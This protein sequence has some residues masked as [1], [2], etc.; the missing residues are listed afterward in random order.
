[1]Q[2]RYVGT[3]RSR[4]L[5]LGLAA[6]TALV[7]ACSSSASTTPTSSDASSHGTSTQKTEA[8][9]AQKIVDQ[10]LKPPTT[11]PQTTPLPKA[12]PKGKT[13]VWLQC[14]VPTCKEIGQGI[15]AAAAAV[16]W[17]L[18]TLS[19][20]SGNPSTLIAAMKQALQY[21]PVGVALSGLPQA[22]WS[23]EIPQYAKAHVPI[24]PSY[25]GANPT[26]STVPVDLVGQDFAELNAKLMAN[27]IIADSGA[28][29]HVLNVGIPTFPILAEF[30]QGVQ[31]EVTRGCG[32][33]N[34]TSLSLSLPDV[35][36]GKAVPLIVSALRRT[37]S[38]KYVVIPDAA[39]ITGLP[40]AL[41]AAGLSGIKVLGENADAE[42]EAN[43]KS[44]LQPG[45]WIGTAT[46]YSGWLDVDV[47][48]RLLEKA[49]PP[50]PGDGGLP[51]QL[52]TR[53]SITTPANTFNLP[54]NYPA[55]FKKLW[56]VG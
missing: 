27:W 13:F 14:L 34:V 56:H 31:A 30:S 38:A 6:L 32:S 54:A 17:N 26:S 4:M 11:I 9:A 50:S 22:L 55:Q 43:M 46:A 49:S 15:A 42:A 44:G 24:I 19:Y 33:C 52:L 53:S 36:G 12:P 29:A 39:Y 5:I 3:P 1:M 2:R 35:T 47:M 40:S 41:K 48:A 37:P 8:A 51:V 7:T 20:D 21:K 28:N 45:T 18:K 23:S 25:I 10:Y 16:G